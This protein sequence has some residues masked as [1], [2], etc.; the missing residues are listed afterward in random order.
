MGSGTSSLKPEE[1][2]SS[3]GAFLE[4]K[5]EYENAVQEA[6]T[7]SAPPSDSELYLRV[8]NTYIAAEERLNESMQSGEIKLEPEEMDRLIGSSTGTAKLRIGDIVKVKDRSMNMAF[9]FEGVVMSM[10][11]GKALI[12][13][14][15]DTVT[16]NPEDIEKEFPLEDCVLT[17]SGLELEEGDHVDVKTIGNLYCRGHI[18]DIHRTFHNVLTPIEVTYD[19]EMET[20]MCEEDPEHEEHESDIEYNVPAKNIRKTISHRISAAERWKRG[21]LKLQAASAFKRSG[22]ERFKRLSLEV[23]KRQ[24][25]EEAKEE[26][27]LQEA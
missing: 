19:V 14:G 17:M 7:I 6:E 11:E 13:F 3:F 1:F 8:K 22:K 10:N 24:H 2:N 4:A 5:K 15:D 21:F 9:Y 18:I 27:K 25:E 23:L 20:D 12:N 16:D 26:A